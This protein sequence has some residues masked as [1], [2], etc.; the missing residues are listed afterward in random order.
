VGYIKGLFAL[1]VS[2]VLLASCGQNF[3]VSPESATVGV[4][5]LQKVTKETYMNGR[6]FCDKFTN[7][8]DAD[9]KEFGKWIDVPFDYSDPSKT[10]QI[11]AFTK[12]E[13]DPNLPSYIFV[14][15]GPGQNTHTFPDILG[16]GFN[17]I[18]FDQR[19]VGCSAPDTWEQY[20]NHE[21]YSS[22]KTANDIDEIRKAYGIKLVSVY[23]VSYGTIPTT[24]YANRFEANVRSIVVEGVLGKVENLARYTHR[25]E[26]YNLILNSLTEAQKDA[27]DDV[28]YGESQKQ[29]YVV[30][31]LLGTAGFR[32]GGYRLLRDNYFKKLFPESGGVNASEFDRAYNNIL[33]EQNPYNTAQHPGATDENV[34][35]RFYCKELGGFAK[36]K[37]TINYHRARGF[38]EELAKD[39]TNW[40]DDC[41]EQGISV[42]MENQYDERQYPTNATVYYL[43]GSHDGATIASGALSHWRSV[44]QKK[45]YF[46]LSLKG[47]HNPGLTKAN[48]KDKEISKLHKQLYFDSFSGKAITADFVKQLNSQIKSAKNEEDKNQS[49][50]TWQLFNSN[51]VDFSEME[52]EFGGL[53]RSKQ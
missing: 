43:Q 29:K 49:Y 39:K 31:Y 8:S 22:L 4:P 45:S 21:L 9:T 33:R 14:D 16:S 42:D 48:S 18:H 53:R 7:T 44:P 20:T 10:I 6:A 37:F 2:A 24:I 35:T 30:M 51:K 52:K 3:E 50:I 32:D 23:G 13:F 25:V 28:V 27:F 1:S 34:L 5:I 17:E 15:G 26:K 47:G 46:M 11:Y 41:K 38:V 12:K 36:D 19:G 40:A